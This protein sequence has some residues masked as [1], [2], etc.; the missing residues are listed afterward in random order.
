MD[1]EDPDRERRE[2]AIAAVLERAKISQVS[3][4]SE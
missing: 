4:L 3:T 1:L 2:K